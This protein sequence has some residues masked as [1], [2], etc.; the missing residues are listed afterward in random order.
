M[1]ELT[2]APIDVAVRPR[3]EERS[4]PPAPARGGGF[5]KWRAR[6]VV[7]AMIAAAAFGA[8][9]LVQAKSAESAQLNIGTVTLT[10]RPISVQ[11]ALAGQVT[12][13]AVHAQQRVALSQQ[14]GTIVTTTTTGTGKIVHTTVTL[15]APTAGVVSDDPLAVGSTLQP[16][17]AFLVLYD[18]DDI[19]LVADVPLTELP[20]VAP[21]MSATLRAQGLPKPVNA[22]VQRVVPWVG[23]GDL[24]ASPD[25][26]QLVLVPK[27]PAD[28]AQL[29]PGLRFTGTVDMRSAPKHAPGGGIFVGK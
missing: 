22:V 13:V 19:T 6:L 12:A 24:N 5:K 18:P 23:N 1:T 11:S 20:H 10:A 17:Q 28:V 14:L 21:G 15:N 2:N 9:R 29:V 7:L 26:L 3:A 27:H 16:G 4:K 25:D 8:Q